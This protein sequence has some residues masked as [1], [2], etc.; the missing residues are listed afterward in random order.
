MELQMQLRRTL[1]AILM[2]ALGGNL[3]FAQHKITTLTGKSFSGTITAIND[4]KITGKGFEEIQL[5]NVVSI[6]TGTTEKPTPG[7]YAI[8]L[9]SGGNLQVSEF[10]VKDSEIS[11]KTEFGEHNLG[12][13]SVRAVL[14]RPLQV[15]DVVKNAINNPSKNNDQV[16]AESSSGPRTAK[17][18]VEEIDAEKVAFNYKGKTRTILRSKVIA[19]VMANLQEKKLKGSI[20][21]I[22]FKDSSTATGT[23]RSLENGKVSIGLLSDTNLKVP[24]TD[25]VSI[26]IRNDRLAWLS[27]LQ[28][29][30]SEHNTI[31]APR[32]AIAK[33]RNFDGKPLTLSWVSG[34]KTKKFARGIV[35]HSYSRITYAND[36]FQRFVAMCGIDSTI[37]GNG[38]CKVTIRAEGIKIWSSEIA[39]NTDPKEIDVDIND[40]KSIE[41]V[42][43]YGKHLDMGDHV[44][45]GN[46]R[47]LKTK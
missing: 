18:L 30:E 36:G 23:I 10:S 32:R 7:K 19:V 26:K 41:I 17:G 35:A 16:V 3:S 40:Y 24:L 9:A 34:K 43:D 44:I 4:G 2:V 39:A 46:A 27:D 20:A 29:T 47:M 22:T 1:L 31:V 42:I 13:A 14:L 21:T 5:A 33:D 37:G 12:V 8:R 25:I 28:P 11:I 45:F 38:H 6:T 15:G